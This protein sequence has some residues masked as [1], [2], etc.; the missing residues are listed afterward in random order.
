MPPTPPSI[1][2][3]LSDNARHL[4]DNALTAIAALDAI[5][6]ETGAIVDF[7]YAIVNQLVEKM[8]GLTVGQIEGQRLL[9]L[10]PGTKD[11]GLFERW[12]RVV[13]TGEPLRFQEHYREGD[14][15]VWYDT[16]A[17]RRG[18][19]L[20]ESFSDITSLKVA[21]AAQQ[22]QTDLLQQLI[23]TLPSMLT[24]S[25]AVRDEQ[26]KVVDFRI[27]SANKPALVAFGR[28]AAQVIGQ[29]ATQV[30]PNDR[31]NGIFEA[32][33]RVIYSGEP[34]QME[35]PYDSLVGRRWF[36]LRLTRLS[37]D[38][39]TLKEAEI[40]NQQQASQLRELMDAAPTAIVLHEA[41]RNEAGAIVDFRMTMVNRLAADW[42]GD[43][44]EVLQMKRLSEQFPGVEHTSVFRHY[45]RVIETGE[46]TRYE[47]QVGATWY[48][49]SVVKSGDGC[50][51]AA[52]DVTETH[53]QRKQLEVANADLV[54][55]N[56]NLAQFAYVASHDLQEPLRKIQSFGDVL[57]TQ[58]S[59]QLTPDGHDLLQRMKA[60][61]SRMSLLIKDLLDYSRISTHREPFHKLSVER[62]VR[63][64]L[65]D[66]DVG[67]RESRARLE[68][69]TLPTLMGDQRQLKQALQNLLS[70]ALKFRKE[71]QS[72][73]IRVTA[74]QLTR[75]QLPGALAVLSFTEQ[76][77]EISVEDNGIGFDPQYAERVF[78][79]FQRLHGRTQYPGTGVGLAICRKV[80]ENHGGGIMVES[81]PGVGSVFRLFLPG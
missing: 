48:D 10:F 14:K 73:H 28:P 34:Y 75:A 46:S 47:Q 22:Q 77:H 38:R 45:C 63:E 80:A 54:R 3:E 12:V 6:D 20:I 78:Q 53:R 15:D 39:I 16:Q 49:F 5:R 61:A 24:I 13:E 66:L 2:N 9:T 27:I 52:I 62:L 67:I 72:P 74:R 32:Y 68:L 31:Y 42:M 43:T 79:V 26:G 4:L 40:T 57:V 18:D 65:D 71:N 55:S 64:V 7:R 23:D 70:N 50:I 17:I 29:L 51:V 36:D 8:S 76:W 59:H 19:G 69:G 81:Q 58:F 30:F 44:P 11:S 35:L 37:P 33:L 25:E 56:D 1:P 41:I 21:E 60:A